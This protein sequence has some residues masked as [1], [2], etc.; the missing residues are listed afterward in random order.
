[1]DTD[2]YARLM[3][4]LAGEADRLRRA[5]ALLLSHTIGDGW[6]GPARQQAEASLEHTLAGITAAIS[7]LDDAWSE[8]RGAFREALSRSTVTG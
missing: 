1:M 7:A 3:A 4:S 8:A 6:R 2:H 5:H